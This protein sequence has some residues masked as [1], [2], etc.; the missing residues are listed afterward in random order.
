MLTGLL[1]AG[2]LTSMFPFTVSGSTAAQPEA[3]KEA[4]AQETYTVKYEAESEDGHVHHGSTFVRT[5]CMPATCTRSA[6]DE[7]IFQCDVCGEE[8]VLISRVC[9]HVENPA[10][11]GHQLD[12]NKEIQ[13]HTN[14][15]G[16]YQQGYC[17]RCE[18]KD[19]K[20]GT[21]NHNWTEWTTTVK[22][23]CVQEGQMERKCLTCGDVETIA[24]PKLNCHAI[25]EWEIT[26]ATCTEDGSEV[27]RCENC[28]HVETVVIPKLNHHYSYAWE[29]K[30][31][32]CTEEGM[33]YRTC[34]RCGAVDETSK[35]TIPAKGHC[36][37]D[38][39]DCT[40][41]VRCLVCN[42]VVVAGK[43]DHQFSDTWTLDT[44]SHWHACQNEGC[45]V[46][47]DEAEHTGS[48]RKNKYGKA[49]CTL[50]IQ[51]DICGGVSAG[52]THDFT[53]ATSAKYYSFDKHSIACADPEC[54]VTLQ[55]PHVAAERTNC[56]DPVICQLCGWK[57]QDGQ[58]KHNYGTYRCTDTTHEHHC[59]N[60]NGKCT[61]GEIE[62]HHPEKDDHNCTTPVRCI[63]CRMILAEGEAQHNFSQEAKQDS[64]GLYYHECLDADC[65]V[66][67]YAD[68]DTMDAK[69][70]NYENGVC[71]VCGMVGEQLGGHSLTL[72][73]QIGVNFFVR[74]DASVLADKDA[75]V[76]LATPDETEQVLVS[77]APVRTVE[78]VPYYVFTCHVAPM[79]VNA[80][81]TA[82]LFLSNG[83]T[84]TEYG[85]SV[86]AY[87]EAVENSVETQEA[88]KLIKAMMQYGESAEMFFDGGEVPEPE[89]K[90][91]ASD[92]AAYAP[93]T[94]SELPAGISYMGSSLVLQSTITIRHYF[95]AED[96]AAAAACGLTEAD[97]PGCY[98][99]EITNIA[100]QDLAMTQTYTIGGC[101]IKYSPMSYV[102]SV[103]NS[104]RISKKLKNLVQSL[105][106]YH[107]ASDS[108]LK[109]V[110]SE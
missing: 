76:Q 27:G 15:C 34:V 28:D 29:V 40:T 25:H 9:D 107:A 45:K 61:E 58:K 75:Y 24:V 96:P 100:A 88:K 86:S 97:T 106:L 30:E 42:A 78:G 10:P 108:Y 66:K 11:L 94:V 93:Q 19:A 6:R 110:V 63:E 26:P 17:T 79:E 48:L 60:L 8:F 57:L 54:E 4:E 98:Y 65:N 109:S 77:E 52:G 38:D 55:L 49:D 104:E 1:C 53:N 31:A 14:E 68:H 67:Q 2:M 51:C 5:V 36:C 92:L 33:Q 35:I 101:T 3:P 62:E 22:A 41:D 18:K 46:K 23:N 85:Y 71:T 37:V 70:H 47:E 89:Q 16:T 20:V 73:G 21:L 99:A 44:H 81:V 13:S 90:I 64:N 83:K 87:A 7:Y 72:D 56:M 12:V 95:A 91:E 84:G 74:L 82:Q 80:D 43:D 69:G 59:L 32:T 102:Y 39:G 50:G 105:Y 103:L